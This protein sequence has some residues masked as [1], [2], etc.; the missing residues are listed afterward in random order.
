MPLRNTEC[1]AVMVL[2][3]Y[4]IGLTSLV[5]GMTS[6]CVGPFYGEKMKAP[7]YQL[8]WSP[9]KSGK[10]AWADPPHL[11]EWKACPQPLSLF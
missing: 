3:F 2:L 7:Q 9:A 11:P 6:S 4:K 1:E 5:L 10:I 8:S